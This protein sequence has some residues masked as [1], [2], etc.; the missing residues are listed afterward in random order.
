MALSVN[1][2]PCPAVITAG[3]RGVRRQQNGLCSAGRAAT[4]LYGQAAAILPDK[5]TVQAHLILGA[6]FV[7]CCRGGP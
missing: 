2:I 4:I 3:D 5:V 7:H 1:A 6:P